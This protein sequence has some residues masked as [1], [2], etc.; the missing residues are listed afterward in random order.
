MSI[1][2]ALFRGLD[3]EHVDVEDD[4]VD[5]LST[6][7]TTIADHVCDLAGGE[8]AP[9]DDEELECCF[10]LHPS[11]DLHAPLAWLGAS[12]SSSSS[13]AAPPPPPP[14][15]PG[16]RGDAGS[17]KE[18]RAEKW[19]PFTISAVYKRGVIVGWGANCNAHTNYLTPEVMHL[20]CCK[21]V[22]GANARLWVM[23]WLLLGHGIIDDLGRDNRQQHVRSIHTLSH[24]SR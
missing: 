10:P 11:D 16:P 14:P 9:L 18:K 8:T 21:Q 24:D 15:P 22:Q 4:A 1:I 2:G 20:R 13:G 17:R 3:T 12:S 19:G 6:M 5:V 7:P 23:K